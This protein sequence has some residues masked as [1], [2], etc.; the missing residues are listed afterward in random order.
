M[1]VKSIEFPS[2]KSTALNSSKKVVLPIL[3]LIFLTT[4]PLYLYKDSPN[5]TLPR[6]EIINGSV[7]LFQKNNLPSPLH[8]AQ[9]TSN[10]SKRVTLDYKCDIFKGSWVPYPRGPYYTNETKCV[11]DDRQNCMKFGRPDTEF[12]KWRWKP[13]ECDLPLF[14]AIEFLELVR[15]KT[16]AFVGDSLG[17]NQMQSLTCLL[18][19]AAYPVDVSYVDDTKFRRWL[20]TNYNFTI[21]ALWSPLLVGARD[22]DPNGYSLNSLIN[23][24]LDE[25][26]EAWA[27]QI[28]NVDIVIIAAGQWFF[29]PF[30]YYENGKVVGCH[31]CH[32]RNITDLTRYYGYRMAFR[33]AFR[34]LLRLQNFKGL[35]ILR[36]YSPSHF[37]NGEW[38][39]GG[40][41]VRTRPFTKEEVKLDEYELETY[42]T[43]VEELRAAEME[44]RKRGLKF[45]MLD[46]TK[47]MLMR[48]DGHPNHYGHWPHESETMA[49]CVHWCMPGPIDTW[50]ELLLQMLKMEDQGAIEGKLQKYA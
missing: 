49:D 16:L 41:C 2:G 14:D 8:F 24:Y 42:L 22:A 30:V 5:S 35:T 13:D 33:T 28:E 44:G 45:R 39:K 47:A 50:N 15:G 36:T 34:T 4:I 40:N 9:N 1:K 10:D 32:K 38:N 3:T 27:S 46:T 29:R 37:E 26:D 43:Q 6:V 23:L 31:I 12:M 11:I 18:A 19:S 48:P 17:R 21:A 20:Y 25:A 7:P